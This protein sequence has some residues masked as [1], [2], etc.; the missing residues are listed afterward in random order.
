MYTAKV[1]EF[2]I[3]TSPVTIPLTLCWWKFILWVVEEGTSMLFWSETNILGQTG[4]PE[5]LVSD[6]K[7]TPGKTQKLLYNI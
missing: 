6:Q 1:F 3:T 7:M 2:L 4:S 5:T